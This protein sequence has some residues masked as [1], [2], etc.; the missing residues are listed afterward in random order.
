MG[1]PSAD[2]SEIHDKPRLAA[3][4]TAGGSGGLLVLEP[5]P[6]VGG[7]NGSVG[8]KVAPISVL[9]GDLVDDS[10][11]NT[12]DRAEEGDHNSSAKRVGTNGVSLDFAVFVPPRIPIHTR[13]ESIRIVATSTRKTP[14]TAASS[15]ALKISAGVVAV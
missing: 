9:I 14:V 3:A 15:R 1:L 11:N 13:I 2:W 4:G 6:L 10:G 12:Q 8:R 7:M 5:P